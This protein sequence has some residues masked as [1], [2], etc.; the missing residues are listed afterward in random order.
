MQKRLI[1]GVLLVLAFIM[2]LASAIT[3][4]FMGS[5][6]D[7]LDIPFIGEALSSALYVCGAIE[8]VFGLLGLLGG[9]MAITGKSWGVAFVGAVFGMLS[10]G[11][12]FLGFVCGLIALI[13][14]L[15]SKDEFP[16][17]APPPMPMAPYGVPPYVAPPPGMPPRQPPTKPQG[18]PPEGHPGATPEEPPT[19]GRDER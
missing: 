6:T 3:I 14:L 17:Q 15:F 16:G 1:A 11:W 12:A 7:A 2:A 10:I 19:E 8:L 4:L 13:L 5:A 18:S 9:V